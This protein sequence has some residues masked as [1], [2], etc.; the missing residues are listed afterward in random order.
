MEDIKRL[1]KQ[2]KFYQERYI[3]AIKAFQRCNVELMAWEAIVK[4]ICS[5]N[6]DEETAKKSYSEI[7]NLVIGKTIEL[8][9][10]NEG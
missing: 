2:V 6:C 5:Q 8:Y 4:E 10:H 9:E 7:K 3:E 1:Q